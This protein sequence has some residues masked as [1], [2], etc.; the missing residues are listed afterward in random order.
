VF[1]GRD[2]L[3]GMGLYT[4]W[5][6]GSAFCDRFTLEQRQ[7]AAPGQ[8]YR[9]AVGLFDP[10][11]LERV[12]E[13]SGKTFVGWM[14][15]PGPPLMEA[16]RFNFEGVYLLDDAFSDD[17]DTLTITTAW[18]TGD[19]QPR[20]L[21]AFIH[22]LDANGQLVTQ[23]DTPLGGDDYP[24]ALWGRHERTYDAAYQVALPATLSPGVYTILFGLYDSQTL[25]RLAVAD[26]QGTPQAD[27]V[28]HVATI[29]R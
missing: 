6:P 16:A 24:S 4:W 15:A 1:Y 13:D 25:T 27:N 29:R 10:V 26:S 23:L 14:A 8:G 28:V 22:V 21:T 3:P 17:A 9:V 19:W 5:Q 12:P 11:T 20:A 7:T 2:S 18:G